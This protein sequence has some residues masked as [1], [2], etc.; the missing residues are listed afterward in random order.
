[1]W[2]TPPKWLWLLIMEAFDLSETKVAKVDG[3]INIAGLFEIQ[4]NDAGRCGAVNI[5]SIMTLEAT[6]WYIDKL[7]E[8]NALQFRLGKCIIN[9]L[10]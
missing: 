8:N 4:T 10:I 5:E 6:R 3:D 1:M 9:A 7:N 2:N